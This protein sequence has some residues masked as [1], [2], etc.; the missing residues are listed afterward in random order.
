ML[1]LILKDYIG[2]ALQV[3]LE[4]VHLGQGHQQALGL[5]GKSSGKNQKGVQHTHGQ[6][7][8]EQFVAANPHDSD[9]LQPGH[10]AAQRLQHDLDLFEPDAGIERMDEM[11]QPAA[12]AVALTAEQFHRLHGAQAF[13]KKAALFCALDDFL[14]GNPL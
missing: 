13:E 4:H 12:V 10:S 1:F 11:I 2:K 6:R 8:A 14:F 5:S 7:I 9:E 3:Q